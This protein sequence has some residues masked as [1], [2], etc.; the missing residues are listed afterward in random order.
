ML[1]GAVIALSVKEPVLAVSLAYL[2]HFALDALPHFGLHTAKN[3]FERNEQKSFQ[4]Y[5]ATGI[6]LAMLVTPL[7]FVW[8]NGAVSLWLLGA[9]LLAAL[10]PDV[11][12][13]WRFAQEIITKKEKPRGWLS[14]LH[15]RIQKLDYPWGAAVEVLWFP[16]MLYLISVQL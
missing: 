3:V 16:G 12:W 7:L 8:L 6:A 14:E 13:V 1:A 10:L 11:V 9:C 15:V 5:T 2:S 4:L